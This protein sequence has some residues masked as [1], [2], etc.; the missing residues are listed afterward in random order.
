M[1][2]AA[3][4]VPGEAPARV[5]GETPPSPPAARDENAGDRKTPPRPSVRKKAGGTG[6]PGA[7]PVATKPSEAAPT[8]DVTPPP[9]KPPEPEKG[10]VLIEKL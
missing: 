3:V 10:P 4:K 7:H 2:R 5:A 6:E 9:A 8:H 1:P